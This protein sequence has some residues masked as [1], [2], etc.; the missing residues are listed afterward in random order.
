[1]SHHIVAAGRRHLQQAHWLQQA[2]CQSA[3]RGSAPLVLSSF[4]SAPLSLCGCFSAPPPL[5]N[6]HDT[7]RSSDA[8]WLVGC[9]AGMHADESSG[10]GIVRCTPR[11]L[12]EAKSRVEQQTLSSHCGGVSVSSPSKH[13][14]LSVVRFDACILA[15]ASTATFPFAR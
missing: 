14:E 7:R 13:R 9:D 4:R 10:W 1:M 5:T 3:S 2:V 8:G 15:V 6:H 11:M 12:D